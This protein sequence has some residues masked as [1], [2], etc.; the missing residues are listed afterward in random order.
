MRVKV[1]DLEGAA[2]DWAVAKVQVPKLQQPEL[3][4]LL[5]LVE[6]RKYKP[7]TD[8]SQG[9]P[10]I[11]AEKIAWIDNGR[12]DRAGKP[13]KWLASKN[14]SDPLINYYGPTWLIASM[15]CFVGTAV[16]EEIDIPEG[17]T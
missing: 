8:R 1:K 9:K 14:L 17:L 10:I 7:S 4:I 3:G 13:Y 6:Y 15:K 2:L 5:L 12:R 16:G 11:T